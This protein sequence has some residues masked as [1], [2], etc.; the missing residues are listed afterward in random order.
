MVVSFYESMRE[1]HKYDASNFEYLDTV[2]MS[3]VVRLSAAT[4]MA[5]MPLI[6][7]TL[8][9]KNSL[10]RSFRAPITTVLGDF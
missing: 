10:K 2:W 1:S 7:C 6:P 9:A 4:Q 5:R 8:G 3:N